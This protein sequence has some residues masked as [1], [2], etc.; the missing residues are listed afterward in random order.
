[1]IKSRRIMW[2]GHIAHARDE[3]TAYRVLVGKCEE[4]RSLGSPRSWQDNIKM[5]LR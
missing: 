4:K 3:I 2:A 5:G 1:M